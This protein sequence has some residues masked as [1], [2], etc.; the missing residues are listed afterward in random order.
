[1]SLRST[2]RDA[3][4]YKRAFDRFVRGVAWYDGWVGMFALIAL[5]MLWLLP[6]QH[7][8]H[9][10]PPDRLAVYTVIALLF[11]SLVGWSYVNQGEDRIRRRIG[12]RANLVAFVIIPIACLLAE[13]LS[14]QVSTATGMHPPTHPFWVFVRW[15]PPV[16]IVLSAGVFMLWK[17]KPRKRVYLDRGVAYAVLLTPYALLFAYMVVGLYVGWLDESLDQTLASAG[18]YAIAIQLVMAYLIGSD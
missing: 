2:A 1:M 15:Y 9:A 4:A 12:K 16:L 5:G 6:R 10:L 8:Q 14:R 13:L 3:K 7:W 18:A 17:S 11:A